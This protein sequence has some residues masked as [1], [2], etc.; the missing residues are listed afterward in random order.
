VWE[1]GFGPGVW[2]LGVLGSAAF[3][4]AIVLLVVLLVRR[5][6]GEGPARSSALDI[7]EQ[8]YARGEISRDEFIERRDVL[9]GS[10]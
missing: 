4:A 2:I 10:R 3:W 6:R 9:T 8:R 7:L 5:P 1:W